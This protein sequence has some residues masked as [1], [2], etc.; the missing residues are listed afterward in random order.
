MRIIVT[1]Y[2]KSGATWIVSMLGDALHLSKRDIYV[3]DQHRWLENSAK[4]IDLRQHP[5]FV[6]SASLNLTDCCVIK[7]HELPNSPLINF[8][9]QFIHLIRDGR[10]VV[11]SKYFY[12]RDFSV[13]NG[14]YE[15]FDVSFDD[16]V[17]QMATE[18][19]NYV[20]AWMEYDIA[21]FKYEDFLL[22]PPNTLQSVLDELGLVAKDEDVYQ[23]VNANT[24]SK[25]KEALDKAHKHNTFIRKGV[26]GDWK[27]YFSADHVSV[28]KELAGDVL[29]QLGYE[30]SSN[31]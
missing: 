9:A 23:A 16:Y 21:M 28:F 6:G 13:A 29:I 26:A 19:R 24:K 7:S 31:W 30:T 1:E 8:P 5:W 15:R 12:E 22:D 20:R 11:V 3:S 14:I 2:P 18:W 4:G 27:H 25:L 17:L 10:D